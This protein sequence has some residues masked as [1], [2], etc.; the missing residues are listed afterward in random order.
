MLVET[1]NLHKKKS[2]KF[3]ISLIKFE[4]KIQDKSIQHAKP[5]QIHILFSSFHIHHQH[6]K[7]K[8][9]K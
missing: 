1:P 4:P 5:A 6:K 7:L 3:S 9:R 2:P 8:G